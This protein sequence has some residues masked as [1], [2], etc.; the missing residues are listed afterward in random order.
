MIYYL[1]LIITFASNYTKERQHQGKVLAQGDII[2]K[3]LLKKDALEKRMDE[4]KVQ[5]SELDKCEHQY[6][7]F[8][9]GFE[10][11]VGLSRGKGGST[12]TLHQQGLPG[13]SELST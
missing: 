13:I 5:I 11:T 2:S 8:F 1:K 12:G 10:E 6:S 9:F 7:S 4:K 3:L